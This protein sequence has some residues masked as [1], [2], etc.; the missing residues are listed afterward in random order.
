M[1]RRRER[2]VALQVHDDFRRRTECVHRCQRPVRA[3]RQRRIGHHGRNAKLAA[4][5]LDPRI[6]RRDDAF[7]IAQ[8]RGG[9]RGHR[10]HA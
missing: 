10:R 4:V 3:G 9:L 6:V 2:G 1:L 7:G 5:R 8:R